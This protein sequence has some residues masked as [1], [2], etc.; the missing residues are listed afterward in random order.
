MLQPFDGVFQHRLGPVL[1]V[2]MRTDRARIRRDIP[3]ARMESQGN[4]GE[5]QK[6]RVHEL[7]PG[8]TWIPLRSIQATRLAE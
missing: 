3:V 6:L 2:P 1:R 5:S 7:A 8:N 4:P